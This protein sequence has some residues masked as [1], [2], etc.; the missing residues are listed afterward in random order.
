VEAAESACDNAFL[1]YVGIQITNSILDTDF[2][3]PDSESW[4]HGDR[5]VLCIAY[6]PDGDRLD[7]SVRGTKR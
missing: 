7:G 4:D 3:Y 1:P 5:K 2:W 6:G